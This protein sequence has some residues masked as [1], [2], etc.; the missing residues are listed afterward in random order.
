MQILKLCTHCVLNSD[1]SIAQVLISRWKSHVERLFLLKVLDELWC[2]VCSSPSS[3]EVI[4][5]RLRMHQWLTLRPISLGPLPSNCFNWSWFVSHHDPTHSSL[6]SWELVSTYLPPFPFSKQ[7]LETQNTDTAQNIEDMS[8]RLTL[9]L[10]I[11]HVS[12]W[13]WVRD[14][15][16]RSLNGN[17]PRTHLRRGLRHATRHTLD[18]VVSRDKW[19]TDLCL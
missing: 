4:S 17:E 10:C 2:P 5:C 8:G 7:H 14:S 15:G 18:H 16:I 12:S 6:P 3:Q 11:L 9:N 1:F 13:I 19:G